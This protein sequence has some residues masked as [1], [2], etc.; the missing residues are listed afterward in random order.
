MFCAAGKRERSR[1]DG[2]RDRVPQETTP[3]RRRCRVGVLRGQ[4]KSVAANLDTWRSL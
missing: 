3:E 1:V 4:K 2:G